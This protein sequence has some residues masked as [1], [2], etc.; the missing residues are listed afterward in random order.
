[1]LVGQ[2]LR[3]RH[4]TRLVPIIQRQQRRQQRD[5]G[6]TAAHIALQQPV[7][8]PPSVQVGADLAHHAFLR[9]REVKRD[10]LAVISVE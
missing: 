1:M 7:H 6:F 5:H 8:V 9:S 3:R 2:N 4:D 10:V